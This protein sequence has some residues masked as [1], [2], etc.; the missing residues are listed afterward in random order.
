MIKAYCIKTSNGD[1]SN[2]TGLIDTE[3]VTL[4]HF[5]FIGKAKKN[6]KKILKRLQKE[7][8]HDGSIAFEEF[9][10]GFRMI[11][12]SERSDVAYYIDVLKIR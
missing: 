6:L 4:E 10:E 1:W 5:S 11:N 12:I 9:S 8:R 7:H 2:K 3:P